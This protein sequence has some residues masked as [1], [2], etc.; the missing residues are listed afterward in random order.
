MRRNRNIRGFTLVEVMLVIAI[1]GVLAGAFVFTMGG[2]LGKSK[3]STAEILVEQM[4]SKL[5][6][7]KL[8]I[9]HYPTEEEGG[10]RALLVQPTFTDESLG[11]K[12][13]GPYVK[14]KQLK[15]PWGEELSYEL[16]DEEQGDTT[17]QVV[18][19]WSKGPNKE[20]DSGEGDDIKNWEDEDGGV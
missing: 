12:W 9:G 2:R 19:L 7:Y 11:N 3:I 20:D 4:A 5:D 17:R 13:A 14:S 15:D 8:A 10:L 1:L 18:H 6:E 16:V